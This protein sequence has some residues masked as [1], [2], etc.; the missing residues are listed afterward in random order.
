MGGTKRSY[1]LGFG[2]QDIPVLAGRPEHVRQIGG[3]GQ[4]L[5]TTTVAATGPCRSRLTL[6]QVKHKDLAVS[7]SGNNGPAIALG[8]ELDRE[9]VALVRCEQVGDQSM[10]EGVPNLDLIVVRA[11]REQ[12]V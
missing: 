9:Y 5:H 8:H 11:T 12:S 7:S 1:G 2:L 4:T 6:F 3:S 10:A